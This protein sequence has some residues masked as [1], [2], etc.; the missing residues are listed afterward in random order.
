MDTPQQ[1]SLRL[2]NERQRV[3]TMTRDGWSPRE[4]SRM[5]QIPVGIVIF[6]LERIA[7]GVDAV[8]EYRIPRV[9]R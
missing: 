5:I 6:H 7:S 3:A 1:G 9:E 4:I 8:P 2:M